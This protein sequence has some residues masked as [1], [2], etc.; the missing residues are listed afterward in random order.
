MSTI[1]RALEKANKARENAA[2]PADAGRLAAMARERELREQSEGH[3]RRAKMLVI[4]LVVVVVLLVVGGIAAA[5]LFAGGQGG[6]Q[7]AAVPAQE[8]PAGLAATLPPVE[9][10]PGPEPT[11]A[12]IEPE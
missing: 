3:R 12:P 4:A 1:L 7:M 11:A 6:T 2:S 9:S 5:V 8:P 10:T